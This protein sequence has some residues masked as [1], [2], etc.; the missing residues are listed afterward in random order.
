MF[1]RMWN[2]V[3]SGVSKAAKSVGKAVS[4]VAK[5][6]AKKVA[7][8]WNAVTGKTTAEEAKQIYDLAKEKFDKKVARIQPELKSL[9]S[10]IELKLERINSLKKSVYETNFAGF[11]KVASNIKN[12]TVA[13]MPFEE[14]FDRSQI[15]F[16][17][18]KRLRSREDVLLID[19]DNLS[20][21]EIATSVLTLGYASRKKAAES[22]TKAVEQQKAMEQEIVKMEAH[23]VQLRV[24]AESLD[25]VVGYFEEI[26]KNYSDLLSRFEFGVNIQRSLQIAKNPIVQDLRLDFKQIP[27][28]HIQEFQAL[29]N[30]SIVLKHMSKMAYLS[31]KGEV[32]QSDCKKAKKLRGMGFVALKEAA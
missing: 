18:D 11:K 5:S 21:G 4:K 31:E 12:I 15:E 14:L 13:S 2:A 6:A 1:G 22:K 32:V 26:I 7:K 19:F 25:N 16:K 8:T 23:L 27:I 29:F 10:S 20:I 9:V 3:K 28:A 30:L 17:A 24:L